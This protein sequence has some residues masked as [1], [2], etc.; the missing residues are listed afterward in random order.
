M[1]AR[2][3]LSVVILAAGEGTRLRPLTL[4]LPKCLVPVSGRPLLTRALE[5]L[6]AAGV[7]RVTMVTGYREDDI[8]RHVAGLSLP[9]P[10]DFVTNKAYATTN[11]TYSLWLARQHVDSDFVLLDGDL[12]YDPRALSALLA[13]ES[14]IA[15]AVERKYVGEVRL[16]LDANG[17]I[18]T[19]GKHV[20]REAAYGESVGLHFFS[21]RAADALFQTVDALV[22]EG[23]SGVFYEVAFERMIRAGWRF[24][25]LDATDTPC[26]EIDDLT[27]LA[28]AEQ[29][30]AAAD[31]ATKRNEV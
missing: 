16:T 29:L 17:Y 25:V 20:P 14:E 26:Q 19:I 18:A 21:R 3:R 2:K 9:F 12:Y 27:D 5:P 13:M 4:T 11:N 6:A 24:E 1:T 10:V 28:R 8:K 15:L 31:L 30:A 23:G 7:D 22:R